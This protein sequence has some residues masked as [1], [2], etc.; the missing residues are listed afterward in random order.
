[1]S[2]DRPTAAQGNIRWAEKDALPGVVRRSV[3]PAGVVLDV[4]CGINPQTLIWPRVHLC[5]EIHDEYVQYLQERFSD[6]T[7]YVIMQSAWR[8]ALRLMPDKSVDSVFALDFI[9]HLEKAEGMAFLAEAERVARR[10]VVVFTPFGYFPQSYEDPHAEDRWGMH[11]GHWQ[12]HRSGWM[13]EDFSADWE[14]IACRE[15]HTSD[16]HGS[17]EAPAGCIWAIRNFEAPAA[18]RRA[19]HA[20]E[21]RRWQQTMAYRH[22]PARF[23][24]ALRLA[25]RLI[26]G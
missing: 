21:R 11:G 19:R 25:R 7:R 20:W 23:R 16:Q 12:T 17:L 18:E 6:S 4:G 24:P 26:G 5:V 1:M 10:Q 13:P 22:V 2:N 9:E 8:D 3:K 14:I 15:Y